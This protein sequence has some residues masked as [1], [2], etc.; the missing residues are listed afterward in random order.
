MAL[1]TRFDDLLDLVLIKL[2]S[3][4]SSIDILWVFT[5]LNHRLTMLII[6]HEF[7][8]HINLSL[9]HYHQFNRILRFLPLNDIQSLSIES[10]A[11]PFQ[12][13]RWCYL[14]HL[15]TLHIIGVCNR[16]DLLLFLLVH[17]TTLTHSSHYQIK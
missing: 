11:S 7:F 6:E 12:L 13:T 10:D 1:I 15:K 3:Y 2:F 4:L 8:Y 16:D 14:S 5:D 9:A 17:A